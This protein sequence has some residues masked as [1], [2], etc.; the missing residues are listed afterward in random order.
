LEQLGIEW[1][2]PKAKVAFDDYLSAIIAEYRVALAHKDMCILLQADLAALHALEV[3]EILSFE[4]CPSGH[5][6]RREC[7]LGH[8]D[9]IFMLIVSALQIR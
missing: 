4:N 1:V 8:A 9:S 7:S 5:S 2:I 3:M 6:E